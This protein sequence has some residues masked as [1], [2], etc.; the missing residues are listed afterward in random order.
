M[1]DVIPLA[2][3]AELYSTAQLAAH[4]LPDRSG[5]SPH[6][7]AIRA[8]A[9]RQAELIADLAH[10]S[11]DTTVEEFERRLRVQ[12]ARAAGVDDVP[13]ASAERPLDML[14]PRNNVGL[15]PGSEW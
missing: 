11:R 12:I 2:E 7:A 4:A 1:S 3:L 8:V 5:N 13:P 15:W 9:L 14:Y 10:D 6:A